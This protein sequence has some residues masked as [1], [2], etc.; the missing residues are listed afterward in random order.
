M[1]ILLISPGSFT[2]SR[3]DKLQY[4]F[5]RMGIHGGD[6]PPLGLASLAAPA[7]AAGH[8]VRI[9]DMRV[10]NPTR[11][12]MEA[13]LRAFAP[14]VV[15]HYSATFNIHECVEVA[16]FVRQVVPRAVSVVGGPNVGVYPVQTLQ[17]DCFDY[18]M[19]GECDHTFPE[20]LEGVQR[21]RPREDI[22]GL[23]RRGPSGEAIVHGSAPIVEDLDALPIP[24]HHLFRGVYRYFGASREP[25]TSMIASR[26][27]PFNCNFC[28]RIPGTRKVRYRS[29]EKLLEEMRHVRSLGYREVNFFDDLFTVNRRRVMALCQ[30]LADARLD[31]VWSVRARVDS[32]D[33]EMLALMKKAGCRRI[34]YGVESGSDRTLGLMNKQITTAEAREALRVSRRLGIETVS[35]FIVGY[36]GETAEDMVQTVEFSSRLETDFASFNM[37]EPLPAS[38]E[39]R[40]WLEAT[41]QADPWFEYLAL[42]TRR[43]PQY[44]GGLDRSLVEQYFRQCWRSFYL[45][46]RAWFNLLRMVN[47][48]TRVKSFALAGI[49]VLLGK[50]LE[51]KS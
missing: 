32:V 48:P 38:T 36:P 12:E 17:H 14:D 10:E 37:F 8:T 11:E 40:R 50:D 9:L 51:G 4:L 27:C 41:G 45:R 49:S 23:V 43:M 35:Y 26:G 31:L 16:R 39:L 30:A 13:E 5:H 24:A 47:S 34:Y 29:A 18:G 46:P 28:G 21:G 7:E 1:K 3:W 42:H 6:S 44:H 15:G 22:Q 20:F 2:R 25:Y 33:E 19:M